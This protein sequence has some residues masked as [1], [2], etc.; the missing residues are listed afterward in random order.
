MDYVLIVI[1]I[2]GIGL[3]GAYLRAELVLRRRTKAAARRDDLSLRKL[4]ANR[5]KWRVEI[6]TDGAQGCGSGNAFLSAILRLFLPILPRPT[7]RLVRGHCPRSPAFAPSD[8]N[9]LPNDPF[10][11]CVQLARPL[12]CYAVK[13]RSQ[14]PT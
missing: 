8:G 9:Y 14:P 4:N 11:R 10:P 1:I 6:A 5:L 12:L 7:V 3:S 2:A 13:D